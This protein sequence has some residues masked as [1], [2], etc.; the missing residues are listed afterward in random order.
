[1]VLPTLWKSI[2]HCCISFHQVNVSCVYYYLYV[3]IERI[4]G[5]RAVRVRA[6]QIRSRLQEHHF[7]LVIW[8]ISSIF[9]Y[10]G[11]CPE[12]SSSAMLMCRGHCDADHTGVVGALPKAGTK[13]WEMDWCLRFGPALGMWFQGLRSPSFHLFPILLLIPLGFWFLSVD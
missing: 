6:S 4:N 13:G 12:P 3:R 5:N 8:I 11:S 9:E 10:F 2:F 1:M 7:W